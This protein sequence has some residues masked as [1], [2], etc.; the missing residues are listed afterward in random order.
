MAGS[1]SD[2]GSQP[3]TMIG[4]IIDGRY[5]ILSCLECDADSVTYQAR[6]LYMDR[7]VIMK[8]FQPL[9][10]GDAPVLA[11]IRRQVQESLCQSGNSQLS[12]GDV[13]MTEQRRPYVVMYGSKPESL[14]PEPPASSRRDLSKVVVFPGAAAVI[15]A[16]VLGWLVAT[17]SGQILQCRIGLQMLA[18]NDRRA[19]TLMWRLAALLTRDGRYGDALIELQALEPE[20]A[21]NHGTYSP[22]LARLQHDV[23]ALSLKTSNRQQAIESINSFVWVVSQGL[24]VHR[25]DKETAAEY[26][27]LLEQEIE[28]ITSGL[29]PGD[30]R[31]LQLFQLLGHYHF[32]LAQDLPAAEKALKKGLAVIET[33][34]SDPFTLEPW[35]LIFLAEVYKRD[36]KIDLAQAA[37]RRALA[38]EEAARGADALYAACCW[39]SLGDCY[40]RAGGVTQAELAF[41]R[42]ADVARLNLQ[43]SNARAYLVSNLSSLVKLYRAENQ[44]AKAEAV[45]R[46]LQEA[47]GR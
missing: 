8:L 16:T 12:V 18:A 44:W 33:T 4:A 21:R 47:R 7:P 19:E 40:A 22:Q 34:H 2:A 26:R 5:Q 30:P 39:Q 3:D 25:P 20:V 23:L 31:L 27:A 46:Q 13:C 41:Q 9:P 10:A 17:P 36:N 28:L 14:Q 6:H 15:L 11:E 24:V 43:D 1:G 32:Y 37:A 42:G 29:G 35:L 45:D 38:V